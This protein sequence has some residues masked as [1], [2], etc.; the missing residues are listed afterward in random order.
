M[1]SLKALCGALCGHT[2]CAAQP[3]HSRHGWGLP[4]TNVLFMGTEAATTPAHFDEQHNFLN[5]VACRA[6][7]SCA[8]QLR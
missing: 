3:S 5:Q 1:Y 7:P 2:L 4:E 6:A 8:T